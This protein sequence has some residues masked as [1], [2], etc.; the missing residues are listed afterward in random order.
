M[1]GGGSNP[2]FHVSKASKYGHEAGKFYIF[3]NFND[4]W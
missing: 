2:R 3:S 4:N 1:Q